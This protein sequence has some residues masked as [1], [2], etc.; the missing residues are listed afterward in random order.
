MS[1]RAITGAL[2][3]TALRMYRAGAS[4]A[5]IGLAI[6]TAT[7]TVHYWR[8]CR[9][10]LPPNYV[11]G[12]PVDEDPLKDDDPLEVVRQVADGT[13]PRFV[14]NRRRAARILALLDGG[15]S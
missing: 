7:G 8:A 13:R 11:H 10:G 12:R 15:A 9:L 14:L 1:S 5:E 4:D 2:E 6:H 3:E